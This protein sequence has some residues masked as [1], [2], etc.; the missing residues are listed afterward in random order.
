MPWGAA[1]A[2]VGTIGAGYLS[3]EA[4][5]D[6]ADAGADAAGRSSAQVQEAADRARRDVNELF[7]SAQRDLLSG[8]SGAYDI[9][10]QGIPEQQRLSSAGNMNAQ[11][12]VAG[13]YDQYSNALMGLPVDQSNW[14]PR[15]IAPSQVPYNPISG[16]PV[17]GQ[18]APATAQSALGGGGIFSGIANDRETRTNN[19]LSG[20]NTNADLLAAIV[21]G[22]LELPNVSEAD[23][24]W[25]GQNAAASAGGD[26]MRSNDMLTASPQKIQEMIDTSGYDQQNKLRYQNLL[27]DVANLRNS[28]ANINTAQLNADE[29]AR[30]AQN[31]L[32]AENQRNKILAQKF[33]ERF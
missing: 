8:F 17:P 20:M 13:G 23:R 10:G 14:Q 7:P 32:A 15:G 26:M 16:I 30:A 3:S 5:K 24:V 4:S 18:Q 22:R 29:A 33:A 28:G 31:Q 11:Q 1:V 9:F 19:L 2:A 6:A 25:W 27:Q 21:S 12:T